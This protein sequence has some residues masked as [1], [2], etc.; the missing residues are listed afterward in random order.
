MPDVTWRLRVVTEPEKKKSA[1][2]FRDARISLDVVLPLP[3]GVR[4]IQELRVG[5][6]VLLPEDF[7]LQ[8]RLT[9]PA[10]L[11]DVVTVDELVFTTVVDVD[12]M[13]RVD[14][15]APDVELGIR[16]RIEDREA[17]VTAPAVDH[18]IDFSSNHLRF[19]FLAPHHS[20]DAGRCCQLA[21]VR[22]PITHTLYG[23]P[24]VSAS[25]TLSGLTFMVNIYGLLPVSRP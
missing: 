5:V 7:V 19:P 4:T 8:L 24:D 25:M 15:R 2:P 1:H 3:Y 11:G 17:V 9:E 6:V 10:L 14:F 13:V 18:R 20:R 23:Y 22:N 16:I 21:R 12:L